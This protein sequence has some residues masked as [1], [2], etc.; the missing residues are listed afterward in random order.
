MD[1][2]NLHWLFKKWLVADLILRDCGFNLKEFIDCKL[3]KLVKQQQQQK[4]THE[5]LKARVFFTGLTY[6]HG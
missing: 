3:V 4:V 6:I 2:G 5:D 1:S